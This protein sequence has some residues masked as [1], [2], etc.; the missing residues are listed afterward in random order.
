MKVNPLFDVRDFLI[1]GGPLA[2]IFWLL[3][4]ASVVI[5][6]LNL[7][8][9]PE[10]R[11]LAHLWN[12]FVRVSIGGLWW[13]QSLWKTPPLYG[14]SADGSGGLR[15]WMNEMVRYASTS[16]QSHLVANVI[17]PHFSFF[18]LQVYLGEAL[19]AALLLIGLFDRVSAILG[20]LMALNL[21]LGLYRS[22]SEWAWEYFFLVVIQVTFL[23]VRP[24][25]SWG[26]DALLQRKSQSKSTGIKN[27]P[28]SVS[29][30]R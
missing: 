1:H 23:L 14:V 22:P 12:W 18:A 9:T 17:L 25:R 27:S 28:K 20:A 19:V 21:W 16:A 13:Q 24:G 6:F 2:P 4:L 10:Q 15:Y 30:E 5:A 26:V 29:E 7:V 8:R 11:S 3:L